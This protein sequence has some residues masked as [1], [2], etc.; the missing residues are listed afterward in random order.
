MEQNEEKTKKRTYREVLAERNPE[1][2]IDDDDAV[3]GYLDESFSRFDESEK[4]RQ[5]LNDLLSK[6]ERAA[7]VLTG[8]ATGVDENGEPFML[9]AYLLDKYWD[10]LH[11]EADK[12]EIIARAKKREADKVKAEAD[13][14][15][16]DKKHQDNLAKTDELLTQAVNEANIDEATVA[17][18]LKWIYG[19]D[20]NA[21]GII[22]KIVRNELDKQD[23]A[24]LIYAFNRDADLKASAEKGAAEARKARKGSAHRDLSEV[25]TNLGSGGTA[26]R[27]EQQFSDPTLE[28]LNRMKRKY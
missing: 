7:G 10:E 11:E 21:D 4:Q 13:K 26:E 23:W 19:T 9:E 14:A 28:R 1:L 15:A 3:T 6:D 2:N 20:D 18:M 27:S 17:E 5:Q 16:R 25:P 8:M 24:R 12:D 22:H